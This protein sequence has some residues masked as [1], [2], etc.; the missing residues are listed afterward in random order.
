MLHVNFAGRLTPVPLNNKPGE[1]DITLAALNRA[2]QTAFELRWIR[3]SDGGDTLAFQ[4]LPGVGLPD[5]AGALR[6]G[7]GCRV[8]AARSRSPDLR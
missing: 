8:R 3:A 1:Q 2:L 5:A 6:R 4:I 7:G